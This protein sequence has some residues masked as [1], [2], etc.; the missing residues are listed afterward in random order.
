RLI[1]TALP[2]SGCNAYCNS[3]WP[4]PSKTESGF[5]FSR[6]SD[7]K[8]LSCRSS[9]TRHAVSH[10]RNC[11]RG[12]RQQVGCIWWPREAPRSH[13]VSIQARMR[14]RQLPEPRDHPRR[15]LR[16]PRQAGRVY[17][18]LVPVVRQLHRDDVRPA[19]VDRREGRRRSDGPREQS[20]PVALRPRD[21]RASTFW[22][23]ASPLGRPAC[24]AKTGSSIHPPNR[25]VCNAAYNY[26]I[27]PG[28]DLRCKAF[29][30][31]SAVSRSVSYQTSFRSAWR[32]VNPRWC[33]ARGAEPDT[34]RPTQS[35]RTLPTRWSTST[36]GSPPVSRVGLSWPAVDSRPTFAVNRGSGDRSVSIRREENTS[37]PRPAPPPPVAPVAS[38]RRTYP[39]RRGQSGRI[40]P[41]RWSPRCPRCGSRAFR[42]RAG[43]PSYPLA[44]PR[45][46]LGTSPSTRSRAG[47]VPFRE[48][49][50]RLWRNSGG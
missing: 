4:N 25:I 47:Y 31:K 42:F 17:G 22:G 3:P 38:H 26:Q 21:L 9:G 45:E 35:K 12:R 1:C 24:R 13:D 5:P 49:S 39:L 16:D 46:I 34:I 20:P 8:S 41:R 14:V 19:H 2:W 48:W 6:I 15:G 43:L 23:P 30:E 29:G 32:P 36:R 7:E 11:S 28:F 33:S 37:V 44:G 27:S 50:L 10:S 40:R 18:P